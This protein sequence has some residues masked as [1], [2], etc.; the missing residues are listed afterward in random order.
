MKDTF[1]KI[2]EGPHQGR[3]GRVVSFPYA[4]N[5][6]HFWVTVNVPATEEEIRKEYGQGWG[7]RVVELINEMKAGHGP[8]HWVK[9][10]RKSVKRMEEEN[11][12]PA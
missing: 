4:L 3:R 7:E 5:L 11:A 6:W 9:V 2:I 1:V 8:R 10:R 12:D